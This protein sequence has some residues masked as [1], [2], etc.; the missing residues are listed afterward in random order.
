MA[1]AGLKGTDKK[2]SLGIITEH[3]SHS[4]SSK[5]IYLQLARLNMGLLE[6]GV[7]PGLTLIISHANAPSHIASDLQGVFGWTAEMRRYLG[8]SA[9]N[10][11]PDVLNLRGKSDDEV[12]KGHAP[13][14]C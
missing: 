6:M 11:I 12:T 2:V 4:Q 13:H 8:A 9:L 10:F 3:K 1:V 7:Y 14:S 5:E